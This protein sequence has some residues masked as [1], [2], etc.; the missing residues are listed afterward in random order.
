MARREKPAE[1]ED[2]ATMLEKMA[3]LSRVIDEASRVHFRLG[4]LSERIHRDGQSSSGRRAI[5]RN[6]I[7]LGPQTVPELARMRPVSRQFI[8]TLVNALVKAGWVS[9]EPNP[10]HRRSGL[11]TATPQGRR[12]FAEMMAKEAPAATWL[13]DGFSVA[14]LKI[15]A[16][17]L[18]T[19]RERVDQFGDV[20]G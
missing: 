8:Q 7:E 11:V 20:D 17:L 5:L 9:L 16:G 2:A 4:A 6:V 13:S 19:L 12:V 1:R 14:D 15:V 3:T 10:A 18:E